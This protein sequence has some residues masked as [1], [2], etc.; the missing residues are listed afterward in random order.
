MVMKKLHKIDMDYIAFAIWIICV[1]LSTLIVWTIIKSSNL[2]ASFVS[3]SLVNVSSCTPSTNSYITLAGDT[4]C[5]NGDI[6]NKQCNG[7]IVCTLSSNNSKNIPK[8]SDLNSALWSERSREFCPKKMPYYFGQ[9][10]RKSNLP[11]GCSES[12]HTP[13]GSAPQNQSLPNCKIYKTMDEE[14]SNIDSC[15]NLKAL[16]NIM[17]PIPSATVNII[18]IPNLPALLTATYLPPNGSSV[19]PVTCYDWPR[20]EMFLNK[21]DPTGAWKSQLK[22]TDEIICIGSK[23]K[24]VD[25]TAKQ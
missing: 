16:E 4:N 1:I 22:S 15:L 23:A 11:E 13:D 21:R 20:A 19:T 5:C 14:F 8:C 18:P 10:N 12:H 25:M 9:I 17:K 2:N 3:S 24:Y 6:V 7:N